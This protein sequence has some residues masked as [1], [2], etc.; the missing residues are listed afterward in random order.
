MIWNLTKRKNDEQQVN[1]KK[2]KRNE[3]EPVCTFSKKPCL[4]NFLEPLPPSIPFKPRKQI[5]MVINSK[6]STDGSTSSNKSKVRTDLA[7]FM[8]DEYN[9]TQSEYNS[10]GSHSRSS[11]NN[12]SSQSSNESGLKAKR[13]FTATVG[14]CKADPK[15]DVLKKLMIKHAN[16]VD[17]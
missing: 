1:E 11:V 2:T 15:K 16:M 3:D 12:N 10:T 9:R 17:S 13:V 4:E 6:N 8:R 14:N 7:S 5:V